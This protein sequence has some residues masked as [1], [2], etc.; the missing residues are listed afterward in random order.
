MAIFFLTHILQALIIA[1]VQ[2]VG[3][4]AVE[5]VN[6]IWWECYQKQNRG[7][8]VLSP[9]TLAEPKPFR[10]GS[11]FGIGTIEVRTRIKP[12]Q[13]FNYDDD[14]DDNDDNETCL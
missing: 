11:W 2:V 12:L 1:V 13:S 14:D 7:H 4:N 3:E 6:I 10:N 9:R 5:V 8:G